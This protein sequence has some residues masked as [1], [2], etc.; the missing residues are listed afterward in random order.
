MFE[1]VAAAQQ[2]HGWPWVGD[3]QPDRP[4]REV[5]QLFRTTVLEIVVGLEEIVQAEH[6]GIVSRAPPGQ[7][8]DAEDALAQAAEPVRPALAR[9]ASRVAVAGEQVGE[10]A[11]T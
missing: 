9:Q 3:R 7:A 6:E 5:P 11:R 4:R 8:E 1:G 2:R 10:T